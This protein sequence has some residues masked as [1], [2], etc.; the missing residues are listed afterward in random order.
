MKKPFKI[1]LFLVVVSLIIIGF[2]NLNNFNSKTSADYINVYF[3][4]INQDKNVEIVEV[5]RKIS[6]KKNSV[7]QSTEKLLQGPSFYEKLTGIYTEIPMRTKLLSFEELPDKNV[8]NLSKEF[9][10]GG[11]SLSMTTR[12]EQLKRTVVGN[13]KGK[14]VELLIE[15]KK[16]EY[17]GGE[18]VELDKSLQGK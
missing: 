1:I 7:Q 16:V 8:L 5:K 17:V 12:V 13:S 14:P 2:I 4:K 9:E 6:P 18:G 11:G 15:G 10:S 3:A